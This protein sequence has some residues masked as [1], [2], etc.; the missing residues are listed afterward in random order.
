MLRR[1][2]GLSCAGRTLDE[3]VERAAELEQSARLYFTLRHERTRLL[4]GDEIEL[5]QSVFA[6]PANHPS[7]SQSK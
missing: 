1:N 3:A 4:R 5:L 6:D 2:H 7:D